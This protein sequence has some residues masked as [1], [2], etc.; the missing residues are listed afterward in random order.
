MALFGVA[1]EVMK[2]TALVLNLL[3][4]SIASYKF[5]RAGHFSWATFWPFAATSVPFAFVGG[6]IALP[7]T[8][9]RPLLGAVLLYSAARFTFGFRGTDQTRPIPLWAALAVGAVIGLLSG[10]T[11]VGGGI[12]LSPVLLLLRWAPIRTTAAVSAHFI[13]ANSAAGLAGHLSSVGQVHPMVLV[14]AV[15]AGIGGWIGS[16]LGSRRL[17]P[18]ILRG[19]LAVVL[20]VA[21]LKLLLT[22]A[23]GS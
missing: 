8:V 23:G 2:P 21:G 5:R 15:I 18:A 16:E 3:V 4:A 13:L 11:G 19:L 17:P 12:F 14:W 6:A 20:V 22:G 10:L 1:P 7:V 9:Y